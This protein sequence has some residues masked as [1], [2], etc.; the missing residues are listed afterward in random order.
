MAT[1]GTGFNPTMGAT[2]GEMARY[3][4]AQSGLEYHVAL[5]WLRSEGSQQRGNPLGVNYTAAHGP[6]YYA[7]WRQGLDAAVALLRRSANYRG[8]LAAIARNNPAAER[9]AIVASPWSGS[10]HYGGG[11]HFS[12]AGI[13]GAGST[14][15]PSHEGPSNPMSKPLPTSSGSAN[16]SYTA[17]QWNAFI[18]LAHQ[19]GAQRFIGPENVNAI[20]SAAAASHI[21]LSGISLTDF[22]GR[23]LS[24]LRDALAAKGTIPGATLVPD[25]AGAIGALPGAVLGALTPLI[26]GVAILAVVGVLGWS[27]TKDLLGD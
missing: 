15:I 22:Y 9:A 26:A 8:I 21:D 2:Y 17:D 6:T 18:A 4:A 25:I 11:A 16:P 14:S 1:D 19:S 5:N 24:D 20:R 10:S 7:N 27:G 3:L 12:T 13:P 23:S